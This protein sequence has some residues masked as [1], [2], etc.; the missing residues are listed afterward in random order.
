[1]PFA[2]PAIAPRRRRSRSG[3]RKGRPETCGIGSRR[4]RG[5]PHSKPS[6]QEW[7]VRVHMSLFRPEK[8]RRVKRFVGEPPSPRAVSHYVVWSPVA[9]GVS[10]KW[11]IPFHSIPAGLVRP[12]LRVWKFSASSRDAIFPYPCRDEERRPRTKI[13]LYP[14]FGVFVSGKKATVS[15]VQKRRRYRLFAMYGV[16]D[17]GSI[18]N[19]VKAVNSMHAD[20]SDGRRRPRKRRHITAGGRSQPPR[21]P[22]RADDAPPIETGSAAGVS[23]T[24]AS[25]GRSR[26]IPA[27]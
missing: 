10:S 16:I 21:G 27:Y 4:G 5:Y 18:P 12:I 13:V 8:L 20:L 15:T 1:M 25:A 2:W 24:S 3:S 7:I 22:F 26:G 23:P 19:L 17:L 6:E 9:R 14:F 11:P